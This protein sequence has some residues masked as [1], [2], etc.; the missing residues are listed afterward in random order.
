MNF[1]RCIIGFWDGLAKVWTVIDRLSVVWK[2]GPSYKEK[3][4]FFQAEIMSVLHYWNLIIRFFG[5]IFRTLVGGRG[6][7]SLQR[8]SWCI[9]QPQPTG[10]INEGILCIPYSSSITRTSPSDCLGSYPDT[11]W[12]GSYSSA[13][14]QLVYSKAPPQPTAQSNE[15]VLRIPY[16]SSITGTLPSDCLGLYSGHSLGGGGSYPSAEKQLVYSTAHT[17]RRLGKQATWP[18]AHHESSC[19]TKK[20]FKVIFH[21]RYHLKGLFHK[22]STIFT[23]AD[24][25]YKHLPSK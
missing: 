25:M 3:C 14:K 15:G 2:S 16:S 13:E 12:G 18:M 17:P 20:R 23:T 22:I 9:L 19:T 24:Y 8:S 6:Q 21:W 10:K 11:R 1:C 7:T 4:S 5:V